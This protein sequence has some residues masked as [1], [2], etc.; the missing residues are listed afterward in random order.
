MKYFKIHSVD[1]PCINCVISLEMKGS[2]HVFVCVSLCVFSLLQFP[3]SLHVYYISSIPS[4][5]PK[6]DTMQRKGALIKY[7]LTT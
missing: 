2:H 3:T 5:E 6:Y 7:N 1:S 4:L